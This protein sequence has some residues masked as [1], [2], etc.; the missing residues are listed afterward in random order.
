LQ[1]TI[2][3]PEESMGDVIGDLNSRRGRVLSL[4]RV[5]LDGLAM[6]RITAQVPQREMLTY[7]VDL[8]SLA[9]GRGSYHCEVAHYEE[10]PMSVQNL[11]ARE[12]KEAGVV[13]AV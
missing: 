1:A 8:R 12:A 3:V 2:T 13:A 4:E 6:Q 9:R 11:V 5:D 10:A 7:A